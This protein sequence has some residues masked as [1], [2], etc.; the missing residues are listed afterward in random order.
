MR[1]ITSSAADNCSPPVHLLQHHRQDVPNLRPC[2]ADVAGPGWIGQVSVALPAL[3]RHLG[4]PRPVRLRRRRQA[5]TLIP[6]LAARLTVPGPLPRRQIRRALRLTPGLRRDR[7]LRQRDQRIPRV[8]SQA[9]PP[10]PATPRSRPS[11]HPPGPLR[12]RGAPQAPQ[13]RAGRR[14]ARTR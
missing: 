14:R 7:I 4:G 3:A 5:R 1:I 8:E 13:A 9:A 10:P 12:Q 11:A 6:R 2:D